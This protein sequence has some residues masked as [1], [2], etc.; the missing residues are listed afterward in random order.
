[1][2]LAENTSLGARKIV[3]HQR[4]S[5]AKIAIAGCIKQLDKKSTVVAVPLQV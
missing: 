4:S 5:D 1:M 3:L 2:Q